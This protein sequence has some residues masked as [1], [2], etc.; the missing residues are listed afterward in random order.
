MTAHQRLLGFANETAYPYI[1]NLPIYI[2]HADDVSVLLV[3]SV[4]TGLC[5]ESSDVD[6]CL[7]CKEAVF[8]EIA[9][10][11]NWKNGRPTEIE[12]NNTQLH[13]YAISYENLEQK[14]ADF[15]DVVFYVY[16]NAI[17]LNDNAGLFEKIKNLIFNEE[18]KSQRKSKS[19]DMLI[20]RNRAL[21]QIFD[22][23]HDPILRITIGLELIEL[24]LKTVALFD[25]VP[26]DKRKRFYSTALTGNLGANLHHKIDCLIASLSE[27]VRE[28]NKEQASVF[29]QI[30]DECIASFND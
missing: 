4:A 15:D 28:E 22:K 6:I 26:F 11:T 29:L 3:G 24:L 16:G 13:Y 7:L 25:D 30:V 23:E 20:R 18:I 8:D 5:I 10:G 17:A 1:L 19:V 2:N 27:I 14:I 21:K 9:K 12:I